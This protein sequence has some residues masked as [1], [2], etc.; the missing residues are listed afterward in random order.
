MDDWGVDVEC[1]AA[2]II[3]PLGGTPGARRLIAFWMGV[4]RVKR[5]TGMPCKARL[6]EDEGGTVLEIRGRL[7]PKDERE[8]LLH[9][10]AEWW[11]KRMRIISPFIEQIANALAAALAA[12]SANVKRLAR[13][14][15][16]SAEA[17]E[18]VAFSCA[19]SRLSAFLRIGEATDKPMVLEDENGEIH[20]RGP[21]WLW[22]YGR[23][24]SQLRGLAKMPPPAGVAR[25]QFGKAVGWTVDDDTA[26]PPP[27]SR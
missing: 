6:R 3:A 1:E 2:R 7:H 21:A 16:S 4:R 26:D 10:L 15:R 8:L 23:D 22:G 20:A 13:A 24:P 25:L 27:P 18:Q 17:V 11:L 19:T 14:T 5:V 9:E 12:P